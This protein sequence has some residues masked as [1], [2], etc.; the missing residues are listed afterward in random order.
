VFGFMSSL[1]DLR[2]DGVQPLLGAPSL[3]PVCFDLSLELRDP[4]RGRT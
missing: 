2:I 4:I 3:L 1:L